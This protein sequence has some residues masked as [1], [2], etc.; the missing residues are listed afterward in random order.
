MSI[1]PRKVVLGND[2]KEKL[3]NGVNILADAVKTTLG[4][5]GQNVIIQRDYG[6]PQVTKD[7]VTVA[8][9][10][11][12]KDPLE[13][14]GSRLVKQA[15]N[16][17]ADDIGDG[18][19]TATVLAQAM[20]REGVKYQAAGI[21]GVNIK[22]G[23]DKAIDIALEELSEISRPCDNAD[24]IKSVAT[25]SANGDEKMGSIIAEAMQAVGKNGGVSVETG[26]QL[27]DEMQIVNG[28]SYE[29]G[30]Y[31]PYFINSEKNKVILENPYI[32]ILDRPILNVND[33]VPILEKLSQAGR[34]FLIMAEQINNDAL[35]TLVV[36]NAQGHISCCA[37]RSPDWKGEKR[38]YLVEDLAALT[39]G[40]VFSDENGKRPENAELEDLGQ[41]NRIEV[42]KD[43][44][45]II[46]GHGDKSLVESR[47]QMVEEEIENFYRGDRVFAKHELEERL[48]NLRGGIAIIKVGGAT[49]VEISE[50][51]D[52]YDDSLHATRAA[53]KEGVVA[54]GGVGYLRLIKRLEEFK[55]GNLEQDAGVKVVIS[56]LTQPLAQIAFNAGDKP[57]F[58]L[59]KVTSLDTE[60]GYDAANN[61]YG[62]MFDTGII[63][64]TKVVKSALA[65]AASVAGMLLTTG[66]AIYEIPNPSDPSRI[67]QPSPPA[68]HEMPEQYNTDAANA[69]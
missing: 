61:E 21:S 43:M 16:Q 3:I 40:T 55:T 56:A 62:N 45:T 25:I 20:I 64:P 8:R 34:Q 1:N 2:A 11:F 4:P 68:G 7:G 69:R 18:T 66:C 42:T 14:S 12:L 39:G 15:A 28:F 37:V 17:T 60:M 50:K 65:N 53:M 30:Y 57:D 5:K 49:S 44:T 63:D 26:T 58:V 48:A 35:A 23:I 24:I 67:L 52:R 22:R 19:T 38:K 59:E 47:V 27:K 31:S 32:L 13:D 33:I 46:G 54:G 29:H 10:I 9:E 36:N 6:P 41:C 51:K